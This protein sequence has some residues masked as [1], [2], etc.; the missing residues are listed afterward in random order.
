MRTKLSVKNSL[1]NSFG[2]LYQIIRVYFEHS[3]ELC[4]YQ[5]VYWI[6]T[7]VVLVARAKAM[8]Q[9]IVTDQYLITGLF[10]FWD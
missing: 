4:V 2:L 7:E 1:L 3:I 8:R 10:F 5:S 6:W 9:R